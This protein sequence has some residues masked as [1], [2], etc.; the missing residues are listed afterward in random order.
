MQSHA[1][2]AAELLGDRNLVDA[3]L[4]DPRSAPI[5]A[6]E[7][8]LLGYVERVTTACH[9]VR[10]EDAAALRA[11]GWTDEAIY[12]AVTVCALFN[13]FVRWVDG[14]GVHAMSDADHHA[15]GQRLA[16]FGYLPPQDR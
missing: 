3:V 13:F 5:S 14:C 16:K 9:E 11:L 7:R 1:A 12:D 10:A 8:A 4:A 2:V 15:S 6:A